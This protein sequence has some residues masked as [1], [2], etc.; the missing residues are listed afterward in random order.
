MLPL[1]VRDQH[2]LKQA[3]SELLGMKLQLFNHSV[4][5]ALVVGGRAEFSTD[6]ERSAVPSTQAGEPCRLTLLAYAAGQEMVISVE[7]F[8]AFMGPLCDLNRSWCIR[9]SFC[10]EFL[11]LHGPLP[12]GYKQ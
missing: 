4:A 10:C 9:L 11:C 8:K 12:S 5:G 6:W 3:E 7:N 1:T 2:S